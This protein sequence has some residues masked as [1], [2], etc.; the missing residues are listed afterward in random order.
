VPSSAEKDIFEARDNISIISDGREFLYD[1]KSVM[2]S[3]P[4]PKSTITRFSAFTKAHEKLAESEQIIFLGFGYNSTN[5]SRL[6]L[7]KL[8]N[9]I[10]IFGSAYGMTKKEMEFAAKHIGHHVEFGTSDWGILE[11]LRERI[12]FE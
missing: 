1:N 12:N 5:I 4:L 8:H 9:S 11:F 2:S 3:P 10:K 6:G 7:N